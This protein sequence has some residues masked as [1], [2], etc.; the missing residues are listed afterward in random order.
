MPQDR[1][2]RDVARQS[3]V[4]PHEPLAPQETLLMRFSLIPREEK[5][6]DM[7]DEV[8]ALITRAADKFVAM[9]TQFDNLAGR[10]Q[11]LRHDEHTCD[12]IV[13]RII[14]AL[15]RSFITPIDREDIH[16]L[17]TALDD[18]M[19]NMEETANRLFS[20]RIEQSSPESRAMA[21]IIRQC[22]GHL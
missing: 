6:F 4:P 13:E 7:F 18:V 16:S 20:L 10:S 22:C 11:E 5:F 19:D 15:D 9:V 21:Q 3:P 17:A 12:M 8:A 1:G 2:G 14:R